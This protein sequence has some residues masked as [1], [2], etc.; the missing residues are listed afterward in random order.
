[1]KRAYIHKNFTER[2]YN[3]ML[4][5]SPYTFNLHYSY[6]FLLQGLT[7]NTSAWCSLF[8]FESRIYYILHRHRCAH[9]D[10]LPFRPFVTEQY[11]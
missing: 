6:S 2:Q 3:S 10:A 11:E 8:L 9:A 7:G 1:M 4:V 5:A